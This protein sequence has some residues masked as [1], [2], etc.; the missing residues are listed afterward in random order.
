MVQ[1]QKLRT[2]GEKTWRKRRGSDF[3]ITKSQDTDY[4]DESRNHRDMLF[5]VLKVAARRTK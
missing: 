3:Y 1:Q 4:I 5:R 2:H